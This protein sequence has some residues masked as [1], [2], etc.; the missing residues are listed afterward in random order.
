MKMRGEL[1]GSGGVGG[2]VVC[3]EDESVVGNFHLVLLRLWMSYKQ[4]M[5]R[6]TGWG[7]G[8]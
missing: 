4:R 2:H 7:G 6:A 8:R 1:G 3:I 5:S